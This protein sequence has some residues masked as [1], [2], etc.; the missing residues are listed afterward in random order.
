MMVRS[1]VEL[2]GGSMARSPPQQ[3]GGEDGDHQAVA[4]EAHEH[5]DIERQEAPQGLSP[6]GQ[7]H[8]RSCR[9]SKVMP[10]AARV[11]Q[12][13]AA[14]MER[15]MAWPRNRAPTSAPMAGSSVTSTP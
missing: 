10:K 12:A 4:D 1:E 9:S 7:A 15:P 14:D 2:P 6:L 3:H 11:T 8:R 5:D 13:M